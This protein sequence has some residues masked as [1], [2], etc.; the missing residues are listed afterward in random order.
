MWFNSPAVLGVIEFQRGALFDLRS[1]RTIYNWSRLPDRLLGIMA[2]K[3]TFKPRSESKLGV[4]TCRRLNL[5]R[6]FALQT[7][8]FALHQM[9]QA[10]ET[11]QH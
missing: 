4:N 1:A 8:R 9:Q 6:Y 3:W 7:R 11:F 10:D 5:N 2:A